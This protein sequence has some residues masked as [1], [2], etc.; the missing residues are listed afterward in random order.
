V[1]N[2]KMVISLYDATTDCTGLLLAQLIEY[3]NYQS[4][5]WTTIGKPC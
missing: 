4:G 3:V 2:Y 5:Y 1:G